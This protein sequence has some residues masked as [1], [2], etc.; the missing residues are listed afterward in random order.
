MPAGAGPGAGVRVRLVT[1]DDAPA[2]TEL[3]RTSREHLAPWEPVRPD[4]YATE[5]FQRR[6][7]GEALDVHAQGRGVPLVITADGAVVGRISVN[8]VVRGAFQSAHLG[9][10]VGAAHTGRGVAGAAVAQVVRLAFDELGLHR[11]QADTLVHNAASR[12]VLARNGFEPIG[13]APRYL[14][15]AGRWQDCV[16]HQRI[17]DRDGVV[18]PPAGRTPS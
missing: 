10:W 12:A 13:V 9:Y 8:D 14:R 7:L 3:L 4:D 18:A 16:L 5:A 2:V 1:E 6:A 11:L 15:I 17:T